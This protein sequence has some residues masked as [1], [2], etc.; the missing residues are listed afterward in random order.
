[1]NELCLLYWE[2]DGVRLYATSDDAGYVVM[3][4]VLYAYTADSLAPLLGELLYCW[5]G[6]ILYLR[7]IP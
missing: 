3:D 5:V 6:D 2:D 4:D 7:Y 1:M